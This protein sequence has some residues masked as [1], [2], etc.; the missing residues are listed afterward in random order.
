[1]HF[2]PARTFIFRLR[3][4]AEGRAD[5]LHGKVFVK[6]FL[7]GAGARGWSIVEQ[8]Y[9]YVLYSNDR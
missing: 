7:D 2:T 1:M 5:T 4:L 6:T 3:P 9:K 8:R